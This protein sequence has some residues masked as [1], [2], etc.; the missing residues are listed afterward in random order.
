M[1]RRVRRDPGGIVVGAVLLAM[2]LVWV[3]V[4]RQP[5]RPRKDGPYT[6]VPYVRGSDGT[7]TR[8]PDPTT[9]GHVGV[10]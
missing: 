9:K 3:V 1:A 4:A 8:L 7:A 5:E 10:P 2:L 6:V